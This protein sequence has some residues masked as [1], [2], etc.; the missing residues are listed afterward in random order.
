M[1]V[2]ILTRQ[3]LYEKIWS[4][5]MTILAKEFNLSDSGLRKI[6]KKNDIPTPLMG[7]WQK[8]QFGKKTSV[9]KLPKKNKEGPIK[10]NVAQIKVNSYEVDFQL[11]LISE[12]IKNNKLLIL[13]VPKNLNNPDPIIIKVK[14]NLRNKKPDYYSRIK[15]TVQTDKGFP[16]ITVTPQNIHRTLLIFRYFN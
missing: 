12:K 3:E 1:N 13:S 9:I 6:C 15:G 2:V 16:K 11:N 10:I 14:E 4:K 8:I 7:H 5:P